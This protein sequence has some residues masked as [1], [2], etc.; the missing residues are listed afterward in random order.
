MQKSQKLE[1]YLVE[2]KHLKSLPR[3]KEM[4]YLAVAQ[5]IIYLRTK[6][7]KIKD[8]NVYRNRIIPFILKIKKNGCVDCGYSNPNALDF[9]HINSVDK[10]FSISAGIGAEYSKSKLLREI[11]KCEVLCSNC[12]RIRHIK[13]HN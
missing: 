3:L 5:K 6:I 8:K 7:K 10:L 11:K 12:H 13:I 2:L 1:E 4:D 9:H